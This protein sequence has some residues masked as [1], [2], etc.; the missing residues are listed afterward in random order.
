MLAKNGNM[1]PIVMP[2][3]SEETLKSYVEALEAKEYT[4]Y[5]VIKLKKY[6]TSSPEQRPVTENEKACILS[7]PIKEFCWNPSALNMP[8]S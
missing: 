4:M 3:M 2:R 1:M 6:A 7:K 5:L 8:N